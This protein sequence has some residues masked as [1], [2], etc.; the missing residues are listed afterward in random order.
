MIG[1]V[2]VK[3]KITEIKKKMENIKIEI[4]NSNSKLKMF[5]HCTFIKP[6]PSLVQALKLGARK[7]Y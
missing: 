1:R 3:L 7:T 4:K 2:E 6:L 5:V